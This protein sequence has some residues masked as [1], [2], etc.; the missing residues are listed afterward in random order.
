[1]NIIKIPV[2]IWVYPED[3]GRRDG[4]EGRD[5]AQ[6]IIENLDDRCEWGFRLI[7]PNEEEK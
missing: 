5:L 1:M 3:S 2:E 4:L 6:F 7:K